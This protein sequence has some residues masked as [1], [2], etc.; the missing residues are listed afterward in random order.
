ML[1]LLWSS[2]NAIAFPLK[3]SFPTSRT[4]ETLAELLNRTIQSPA[5]PYLLFTFSNHV[6]KC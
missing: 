5:C 6:T 4:A 1:W 2:H 3:S